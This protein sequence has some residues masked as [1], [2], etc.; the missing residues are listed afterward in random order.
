MVLMAL[1]L[2]VLLGFAS[3]VID[4]GLMYLNSAKVASAADAAALAGAQALVTG[5]DEAEAAA[6]QYAEKNGVSD[7]AISVNPDN[8]G[9]K[10]EARRS[11]DLYL[12][13]AIGYDSSTASASSKAS[14]QPV[15]AVKGIVPLGVVEQEF[16][17]GEKYIL[18]YGGGDQPEGDA[19]SGWLGLLALQGPG[20][21]LYLEDLKYGFGETVSVGDILNIQTGNIS[22]NTYDGVQYRLDQ[23]KHLPCCTPESFSADCSRIV[24]V[25][26][27]RTNPGKTVEVV[28]FS[29]FFLESV[30]GMGNEN[31]I[32]GTFIKY[33]VAG[34][35]SDTAP[36][37]GVYV[38]RLIN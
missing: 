19:H 8:K 15:S 35:G 29:A 10:V 27:I 37:N 18:K 25:P 17:F 36:D 3:L 33:V 34:T 9:L 1:L 28:G 23:C 5:S 11:I 6:R 12:A 4:V 38:P 21:K 32:T 13:R 30:A 26:V 14:L 31:Y 20:A 16:A 24:I 7:L 22:G 2:V